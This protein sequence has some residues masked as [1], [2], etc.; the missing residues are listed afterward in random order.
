MKNLFREFN[1]REIQKFNVSLTFSIMR[2]FIDLLGVLGIIFAISYSY[3]NNVSIGETV[4]IV[5][6]IILLV[7]LFLL[8]GYIAQYKTSPRTT[9]IFV[10]GI[11]LWLLPITWPIALIWACAEPYC[12]SP[13][14]PIEKDKYKIF[15]ILS[16]SIIVL[17][18]IIFYFSVCHSEVHAAHLQKLEI[19]KVEKAVSTYHKELAHENAKE[20]KISK[21][22]A[23]NYTIT[24]RQGEYT[25]GDLSGCSEKENKTIKE[26][27][28]N[29]E[30]ESEQQEYAI[31]DESLPKWTDSG[32]PKSLV[33]KDVSILCFEKSNS[34]DNSQCSEK[35]L[36][37]IQEFYKNNEERDWEYEYFQY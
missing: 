7:Q 5:V 3:I 16:S 25:E 34:S 21:K 14:K 12:D 6:G 23:E 24:Q 17:A 20:M 1:E 32:M 10:T 27:L 35:E 2:K 13:V 19:S 37:T 29:L 33:L 18:S 31:D 9:A 28:K 4:A 22:C 15:Q 26:Y 11:I 36:K 30:K 8:P